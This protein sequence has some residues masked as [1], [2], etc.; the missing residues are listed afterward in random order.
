MKT[1]KSTAVRKA[2]PKLTH[3]K[4]S[5]YRKS[6]KDYLMIKKSFCK[7]Y[8]QY[9]SSIN[10]I[11][12][13]MKTTIKGKQFLDCFIDLKP[14][15]LQI[16]TI[17]NYMKQE[18][19]YVSKMISL[20]NKTKERKFV[21]LSNGKPI[22][23]EKFTMTKIIQV[24]EYSYVRKTSLSDEHYKKIKRYLIKAYKDCIGGISFMVY[25]LNTY[26]QGKSLLNSFA[27][28]NGIPITVDNIWKV[29]LP[30]EKYITQKIDLVDGTS[31]ITY[32]YNAYKQL[33]VK[34]Y[35]KIEEILN[36]THRYYEHRYF[37]NL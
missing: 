1:Q 15:E 2:R 34:Q 16:N 23:I 20:P 22:K 9:V 32:T 8:N 36:C 25:C 35:F 10:Y 12:Q 27:A 28:Y 30:E 26:Q 17:I 37:G 7:N 6:K 4:P 18:D 5:I 11:L 14:Y 19:R 29:M 13:F 3:R 24:I 31:K 33:T 21:F